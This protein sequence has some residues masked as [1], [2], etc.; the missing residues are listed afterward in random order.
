MKS[1]VNQ[2]SFECRTNWCPI[3]LH[4]IHYYELNNKIRF[5]YH[6]LSRVKRWLFLSLAVLCILCHAFSQSNKINGVSFVGPPKKIDSTE[7]SLPKNLINSNYLSVMPYGFI[8]EG[9]TK[10]EYN[11]EWQWWGEK[12]EGAAKMIQMAKNKVTKSC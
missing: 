5:R 1:K 2:T 7:I 10:L 11:N 12:T 8:P 3:S 4:F 6:Y 9:S